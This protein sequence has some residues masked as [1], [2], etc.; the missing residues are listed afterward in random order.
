MGAPSLEHKFR[1]HVREQVT[2]KH[3]I[4]RPIHRAAFK[5]NIIIQDAVSENGL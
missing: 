5:L 4:S 3:L 1:F 2:P